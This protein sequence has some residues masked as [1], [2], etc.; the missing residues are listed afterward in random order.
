[1]PV[2]EKTSPRSGAADADGIVAARID[3]AH[4]VPPVEPEGDLP[5]A[6][7]VPLT[8]EAALSANEEQQL[9]L[10]AAQLARQLDE[11][12][13]ELDRR[14]SMLNAQLAQG[15]AESRRLRLWLTER[16]RDFARRESELV[17]QMANQQARLDRIVAAETGVRQI[18][19][20]SSRTLA[21][22]EEHVAA[23]AARLERHV[24]AA[25][26]RRERRRRRIQLLRDS[27]TTQ[28]AASAQSLQ[29]R[30]R[31][32][33]QAESLVFAQR[34]ELVRQTEL[35]D[36]ERRRVEET[37]R[38]VRAE[39]AAA[40]EQANQELIDK[41]RALREQAAQLHRRETALSQLRSEVAAAQRE[42]LEMRLA[43]E[44]LWINLTEHV[45]SAELSRLLA[46]L[47]AKLAENYRLTTEDVRDVREELATLEV[48]LRDEAA[49]LRR[50]RE[51]FEQFVARRQTDLVEQADRLSKREQQLD[52]QEQRQ[53]EL[54]QTWKNEQFGYQQEISRLLG[55][56]RRQFAAAE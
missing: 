24:A 54:A 21:E 4:T 32:L 30:E 9:R 10:H 18:E 35:L 17:E 41:R 27:K 15:D 56:L 29:Q 53:R 28:V 13:A 7:D 39:A 11:R 36:A 19:A 2:I 16:E 47:R 12:Q 48:R 20:A 33:E 14:E 40:M 23:M 31:A 50:E 42:N 25:R 26:V 8:N 38:S 43:T 46:E 51:S 34:T 22:R 45:P 52:A 1:M 6:P 3:R 44:E 37:K 5:V 55:E 49:A